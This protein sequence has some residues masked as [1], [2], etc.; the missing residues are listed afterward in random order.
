MQASAPR[1]LFVIA[2][3]SGQRVALDATS[4]TSVVDLANIVPVPLMPAHI[5]GLCA[6]RSRILT[7]VD[8]AM[9]IKLGAEKI[10]K[11]AITMEIERHHYAVIVNSVEQVEPGIGLVCPVDRSI[12][13][14]WALLAVGT[15]ETESGTALLLDLQKLFAVAPDD[16][17]E[18]VDLQSEMAN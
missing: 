2:V 4:V 8:L 18:D 1:Q 15:I 3:V 5:L 17:S 11:R 7:V 9:A 10:S 12:G 13:R 16:P 14:D 6:I